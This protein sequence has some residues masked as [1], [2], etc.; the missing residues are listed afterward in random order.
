MYIMLA[1]DDPPL[2]LRV[3]L[4]L[5]YYSVC[6]YNGILRLVSNPLEFLHLRVC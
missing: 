1:Y 4:A 5:C 3:N 2:I 6:F